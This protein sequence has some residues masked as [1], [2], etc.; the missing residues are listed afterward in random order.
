M[1]SFDVESPWTK[2]I[3]DSLWKEV[4]LEFCKDGCFSEALIVWQ[5]YLKEMREWMREEVDTL[6]Q[7]VSLIQQVVSVD[8][9]KLWAALQLLELEVLPMAF[10]KDPLST[11]SMCTT[12]LKSLAA[13]LELQ[14]PAEFP[15]N[16]LKALSVVERV[17]HSL[18]E[19][20]VTP[21][22][23]AEVA[24]ILMKT[25]VD[26]E[27][28]NDFM[29][30]LNVYVK[31]LREMEKLR[32]VYECPMTYAKYTVETV[33]SICYLILER[34]RSV[35]LIKGN[36]ERYAKP[37]M[38]EHHLDFNRTLYNYIIVETV[39]S[40]C[41][42]IL[43]RVRSVHLIK[44]NIERYAKP[45]MIEHHLDFNR[46][47]YNY[48]IKV[49]SKCSA[50]VGDSNPWDERCLAVAEMISC[51]GLRCEALIGIARRAH[52]PWSAPL[53]KAIQMMLDD[54]SLDNT[55]QT[56]LRYECDFA[57]FAQV[58]MRYAVPMATVKMCVQSKQIFMAAIDFV[59]REVEVKTDPLERL[60]D[61]LTIVDLSQKIKAGIINRTD[62]ITHFA[63]FS[64]RHGKE[65]DGFTLLIKC[66]THL[67]ETERAIVMK[68]IIGHVVVAVN[69]PITSRNNDLR[70][71]KIGAAICILERF[72]EK[73][74]DNV[75]L[76]MKLRAVRD[77]QVKYSLIVRLNLF[78]DDELKVALLKEF[79][80]D[81]VQLL[82]KLRAVRDLQVKYSLTVRLNL[83]D[84]DELKVALLKEFTRSLCK[85]LLINVEVAFDVL[86]ECAVA[87]NDAL[88]SLQFAQRALA[89][90][91]Q[92]SKHFLDSLMHSCCAAL[93]MMARMAE[94]KDV[95]P[96]LA[97]VPTRT[98]ANIGDQ[99]QSFAAL[100]RLER[101]QE[102]I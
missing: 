8:M 21:A 73:N 39:E 49:S 92:P 32:S 89:D 87:H 96:G 86:L 91:D 35:H 17:M 2:F 82:M 54:R 30:E 84:D 69:S 46:T 65:E 42:L 100:V 7:I 81:N 52:P 74:D 58:M 83:F 67:D 71:R 29:G 20:C 23:T 6:Q 95:E 68:S 85:E 25:R 16:A 60:Q 72:A 38:I 14:Q 94:E 93:V 45:Y 98:V 99:K 4:F 34:V 41:Y 97:L 37:Y 101:R 1:A 61:A 5:R 3:D 48:I 64:I 40:I 12:W 66:L 53:K 90:I 70:L 9:S 77:L 43:E 19:E 80:D 31:N 18:I 51:R 44:G 10:A 88:S 75:Q 11:I 102:E 56:R 55:M 63:I 79:S 76:L 22:E 13:V 27:D 62:C 78:D 15:S 24:H 26:S 59:F 36:I 57:A 28:V 50:S 47:L 33:E